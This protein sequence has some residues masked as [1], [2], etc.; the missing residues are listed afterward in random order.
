[1]PQ[2][3]TATATALVGTWDLAPPAGRR[4]PHLTV[5][6]DSA[7]HTRFYGRLTRVLSGDMEMSENFQPLRGTIDTTGVADLPIRTRE[8]GLPE[9]RL[10]GRVSAG[11]W[12]LTRFVW[13]GE[14]QVGPR[15][16]WELRK[17]GK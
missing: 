11:R 14:E 4:G 5:V 12:T 3:A 13:S 10:T 1:V 15:S 17:A 6:I 8:P 9:S 7:R 16:A 2:A